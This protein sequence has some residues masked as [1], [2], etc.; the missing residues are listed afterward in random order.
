MG[1]IVPSVDSE[2]KGLHRLKK[3]ID[4]YR[5][6]EITFSKGAFG[7][8]AFDEV[9]ESFMN[10]FP[11][12]K[13][14]FLRFPKQNDL[15]YFL[16]EK[17]EKF[18]FFL[19]EAKRLSEEH[20]VMISFIMETHQPVLVYKTFFL[21]SLKECL[22]SIQGYSVTIYLQNSLWLEENRCTALEICKFF[23]NKQ[24]K[25]CLNFADFCKKSQILQKDLFEYKK[26]YLEFTNVSKYMD[27]ILF[28]DP[29]GNYHQTKEEFKKDLSLFDQETI[30]IILDAKEDS[31]ENRFLQ[32]REIGWFEDKGEEYGTISTN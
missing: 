26:I 19:E 4:S 23:G 30:K 10:L 20:D 16:W 18:L 13:E 21:Y 9:V 15:E 24:L 17:K 1:F 31:K 25:L 32:E 7:E 8:F 5:K 6:I 28:S 11:N 22:D 27:L 14:I 3:A 29:D 12:T 2:F